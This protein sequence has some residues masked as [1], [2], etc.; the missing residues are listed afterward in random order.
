[1]A[2]SKNFR[3]YED[4]GERF[5][6]SSIKFRTAMKALQVERKTNS[7]KKPALNDLYFEIGDRV[8]IGSEAIKQWYN[9]NNGPG[10]VSMI[11]EAAKMLGVDM[12]DLTEAPDYI[13]ATIE[14]NFVP[15]GSDEK[16]L[17]RDMYR[18][19][20]NYIYWFVGTESEN[21]ALLLME[22]A[23]DEECKYVSGMYKYLDSIALDISHETYLKLRKTITE[24]KFITEPHMGYWFPK[25]WIEVNPILGTDDFEVLQKDIASNSS[26]I[27]YS[28][29]IENPEQ[30]MHMFLE[31]MP[32]L[33][34]RVDELHEAGI[35]SEYG[36]LQTLDRNR[37]SINYNIYELIVK[38][39]TLSLALLMKKRFANL[40]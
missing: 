19:F 27:G 10:D 4:N 37:I 32:E 20:V 2:K 14:E 21:N 3:V 38:E 40:F 8:G 25:T 30:V 24:L 16:T 33:V 26:V 11:K 39:A 7:G 9:G 36:T 1:M 13:G 12:K 28:E 31:D 6:F 35:D 22:D 5:R 17:V 29:Y 34:S 23:Y 18:L 15:F